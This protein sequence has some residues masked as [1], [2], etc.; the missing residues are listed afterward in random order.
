M[1][2]RDALPKAM[3]QLLNAPGSINQIAAALLNLSGWVRA[4]YSRLIQLACSDN[5]KSTWNVWETGDMT[6]AE[7]LPALS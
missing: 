7:D 4:L 5:P 3:C 1:R 6:F 2:E